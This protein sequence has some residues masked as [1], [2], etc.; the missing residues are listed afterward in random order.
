MI[1][2]SRVLILVSA[3]VREPR[4]QS[5]LH[6]QVNVMPIEP[7]PRESSKDSARLMM[8][9]NLLP[10]ASVP[11]FEDISPLI[12]PHWSSSFTHAQCVS[13]VE[14]F[15][16]AAPLAKEAKKIPE[17]L[18]LDRFYE[19]IASNTYPKFVERS[20][21]ARFDQLK[22]S[23]HPHAKNP[24]Q[25]LPIECL[26]YLKKVNSERQTKIDILQKEAID[27]RSCFSETTC[28][29]PSSPE[30]STVSSPLSTP[31]PSTETLLSLTEL[32]QKK[33]AL[34]TAISSQVEISIK[35]K[36]TRSSLKDK[37]TL[38]MT[39]FKRQQT[40]ILVSGLFRLSRFCNK[41]EEDL[42]YL[43]GILKIKHSEIYD[44]LKFESLEI[45]DRR[46]GDLRRGLVGKLES[47]TGLE[48]VADLKSKVDSLKEQVAHEE[49]EKFA[50]IS[51]RLS[52]MDIN[53]YSTEES[54]VGWRAAAAVSK[55]RDPS[56]AA[57][58]AAAGTSGGRDSSGAA[59]QAAAAVSKGRD[60]SGAAAQAAAGMSGG[61]DSSGAAAQA[62]AG[63]S[64]GRAVF[65]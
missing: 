50:R 20:R 6:V 21:K 40:G 22:S 30:P 59:A 36:E 52:E 33:S 38:K 49:R 62:A 3:L 28:S 54:R 45:G 26:E 27:Q 34:T 24:L 43:I 42:L 46:L 63:T 4:A 61:R 16:E 23:F 55:G 65:P 31:A 1:S 5:Q 25:N 57:A 9:V 47:G 35:L 44:L 41:N 8:K 18:P 29:D 58:Q 12:T 14:Q 48:E 60:P 15:R 2:P 32:A 39:E 7:V 13:K 10:I 64:G 56:G 37:S 11:S 19:A 17:T 51:E 53:H